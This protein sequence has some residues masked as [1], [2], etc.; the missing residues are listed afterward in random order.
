MKQQNNHR[1]TDAQSMNPNI[2]T[3]QGQLATS[4]N[5]EAPHQCTK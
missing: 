3:A 2:E 1:V 5:G 4:E